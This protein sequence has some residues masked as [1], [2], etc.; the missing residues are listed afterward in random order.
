[1]KKVVTEVAA[2]HT[3]SLPHW[4]RPAQMGRMPLGYIQD[5]CT[6][7]PWGPE[8]GR[9]LEHSPLPGNMWI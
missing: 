3:A 7:D 8:W 2:S 6:D 4:L 9:G 1:M 5:L